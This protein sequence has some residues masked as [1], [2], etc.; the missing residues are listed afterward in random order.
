MPLAENKDAMAQKCTTRF[1]FNE[2]AGSYDMWYNS[3]RGA[4]YDRLEKQ[5]FDRLLAN[6]NQGKSLLEIGCGTGHWSRYFSEKGFEVTGIDISEEMINIARGK[7]IPHCCFQMANGRNLP[8][9]DNS[10][11]VAAAITT[12]EFTENPEKMLSE[13]VRCVNSPGTLLF[14]VLNALSTY[15]QTMKRHKGSTYARSNLFSP[16]QLQKLLKPLGKVRLQIAGFIPKSDWLIPLSPLLEC[17]AQ[18]TGSKRG[19]FIA[20]KV[21]L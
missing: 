20:A 1:D 17:I 4:M 6:D 2:A 8:F 11:D 18:L 13:M 5:A 21:G 12:L 16:Q 10:F 9:A 19:A 14:G 3:A 7:N 15:N